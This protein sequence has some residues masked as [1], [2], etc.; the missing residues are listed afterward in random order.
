M[1][2]AQLAASLSRRQLVLNGG[3]IVAI[4]VALLAIAKLGFNTLSSARAYVGGEGL[5]S[6]AQKDAVHHL[7]RFTYKPDSLIY[8]EFRS[9][10]EVYLGDREARIAVLA[11]DPDWERV[12]RGFLRGGNHPDDLHGMAVF[13]RRFRSVPFVTEAIGHWE[14]GDSLMQRL[15]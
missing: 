5:W 2:S 15:E 13:L 7:V 11:P 8:A 14:R 3:L 1:P 4:V 12:H 6:K 10:L 9:S